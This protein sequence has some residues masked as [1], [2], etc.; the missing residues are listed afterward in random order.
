MIVGSCIVL[1]GY[2]ASAFVNSV[3]ILYLT[4]GVVTGKTIFYHCSSV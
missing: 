4:Y 1:I 2:T 3:E